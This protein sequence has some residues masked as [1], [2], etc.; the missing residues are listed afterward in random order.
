MTFEA[1][2][3][4]IVLAIVVEFATEIIKSLFPPVRGHYSKLIAILLGMIL[5]VT[6]TSG[7]LSLFDIVPFY[8]LLDYLLTGLII[9][10]GSN[11]IHDLVSRLKPAQ[12]KH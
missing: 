10:R 1:L 9:S 3:T 6:T 11:I 12:A 4:I 8:P 7:L 2:T 5:C